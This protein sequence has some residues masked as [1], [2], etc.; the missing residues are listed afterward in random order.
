MRVYIPSMGRAANIGRIGT[1]HDFLKGHGSVYVVPPDEVDA[2]KRALVNAGG[3]STVIACKE[4]GIAAVRHWIGKEAR[5]V[6]ED[7]FCMMDD[8]LMFAVRD[9]EDDWHLRKSKEA[10]V[11]QMLCWI[12]DML[13]GYAHVSISPRMVNA[14]AF[15]DGCNALNGIKENSRT[16]RVLA[17]QTEAFLKMK[18]GRVPVM[19]DFDVNLQLLEAGL[20]N[21]QSFYWSNDQRGTGEKGGCSS[22]RTLE[23]HN[24]AATK[25]QSLHPEFVKLREKENKTGAAEL[26][27]RLEVTIQWGQAFA[28]SQRK[29][30]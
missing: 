1:T 14:G 13:T 5:R 15:K 7:K 16:L 21:V 18:H 19:E 17:Y 12:E 4:Q 27:K 11:A 10:D 24:A 3:H 30:R 22:Y 20:K 6:R 26:R 29:T 23:A 2:Y 8:D 9:S 25:L 28:S